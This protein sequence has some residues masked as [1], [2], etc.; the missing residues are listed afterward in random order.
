[1]K[2]VEVLIGIILIICGAI[3][4]EMNKGTLTTFIGILLI[5]TGVIFYIR[6]VDTLDKTKEKRE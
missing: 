2:E 3:L 5:S 4:F 1:M 6:S